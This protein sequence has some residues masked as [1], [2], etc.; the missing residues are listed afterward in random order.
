MPAYLLTWNPKKWDWKTLRDEVA[1]VRSGRRVVTDWSAGVTRRIPIGSRVYLLRQGEEPRGIMG[2]GWT[3]SEV[4]PGTHWDPDREAAGRA[5]NY[6]QWHVEVLLDPGETPPLDVRQLPPGPAR[7]ANWTPLASGTSI[8]DEAAAQLEE[9][10]STY[11]EA[12]GLHTPVQS[13]VEAIEGIARRRL[14]MHRSRERALREA[15]LD[16]ARADS[17]DGRIRCEVPGCG[18]DF[19]AVYGEIGRGFAHV[20]HLR[21]LAE[22]TG[23]T[24]TALSDLA[25]VCPNCH[26]MI[27]VGG[28]SRPLNGL[29]RSPKARPGSG[30]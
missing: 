11:V 22:A 24:R 19:E 27:H 12:L 4:F 30:L 26:A 9:I 29:I 18:F 16:Q 1:R 17:P 5:A 15:K 21:P 25:V 20:H 28:K 14:V 2:S 7:Q 3:T 8:S 10:W 23:P 6:L 13:E